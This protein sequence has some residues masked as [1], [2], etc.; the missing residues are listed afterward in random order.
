MQQRFKFQV[1][2]RYGPRCAVCGLQI[3]ALLQAAHIVPK[4]RQGADDP[5]NGLVLCANHHLAFDTNLFAIE[6]DS[7]RICYQQANIDARALQIIYGDLSH[8]V[9]KPHKDAIVWRYDYWK[10]NK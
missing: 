9:S 2:K 4:E 5:R 3:L 7:L 10:Q 8:L 6:P 1:F